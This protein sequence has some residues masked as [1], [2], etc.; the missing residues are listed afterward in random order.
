MTEELFRDDAYAKEC[1]ATVTEVGERGIQLDRTVFYP[2]GGGKISLVLLS[3][4]DGM[5]YYPKGG[6]EKFNNCF[7]IRRTVR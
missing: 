2:A 3:A 4:L 6:L 1:E 7:G 5:D